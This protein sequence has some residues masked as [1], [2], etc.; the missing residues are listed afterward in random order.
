MNII[1]RGYGCMFSSSVLFHVIISTGALGSP[2]S[3]IHCT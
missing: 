3:F 1:N 2:S